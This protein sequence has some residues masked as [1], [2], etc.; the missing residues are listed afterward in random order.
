MPWSPVAWAATRARISS[1]VEQTNRASHPGTTSP[2]ANCFMSGLPPVGAPGTPEALF[3]YPIGRRGPRLEPSPA[4]TGSR[5]RASTTANPLPRAC[6]LKAWG[7]EK[8]AG[9]STASRSAAASRTA[10]RVATEPSASRQNPL[11]QSG[12]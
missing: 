8:W 10:R 12:R 4:P 6:T 9:I 11:F 7:A 2:H 3:R 5:Y 1:S